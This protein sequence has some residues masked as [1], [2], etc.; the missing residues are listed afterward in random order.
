M[1]ERKNERCFEN[2]SC[3]IQMKDPLTRNLGI[4]MRATLQYGP[5]F[6]RQGFKT[7]I[8]L[9]RGR[10]GLHGQHL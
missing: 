7:W 6:D 3:K 1:L 4:N 2:F 9:S 8:G 10:I 5:V